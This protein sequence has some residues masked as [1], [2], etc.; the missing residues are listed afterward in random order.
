MDTIQK[1]NLVKKNTAEIV[2]EDE[3][4][5]VLQTNTSP[6]AYWGFECSGQ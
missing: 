6:K 1:Y 5:T 4:K 2:T 3:L